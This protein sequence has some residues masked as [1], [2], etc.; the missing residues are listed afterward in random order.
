MSSREPTL[1]LGTTW[2]FCRGG[3]GKGSPGLQCQLSV[4][5]SVLSGLGLFDHQVE[6]PGPG[7]R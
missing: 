7:F 2:D 5:T 6:S 3:K 1:L 4:D